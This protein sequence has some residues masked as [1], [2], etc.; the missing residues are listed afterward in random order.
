MQSSSG[1]GRQRVL[2]AAQPVAATL[3]QAELSESWDTVLAHS[4][5]D[6]VAIAQGGNVAAIICTVAFDESRM[7][8][9]LDACKRD[10]R[11][12]GIGFLCC[13][14]LP[15]LLLDQSMR[16]LQDS[17]VYFGA[18]DFIDLAG[19]QQ[20]LG[21]AAAATILLDAMKKCIDSKS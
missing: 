19:H 12:K 18:T 14:V 11:T 15:S 4:I 20:R 7:F 9:F 5:P 10:P 21:T 8:D 13:R 1:T 2:I 6:A 16:R 3:L 17:C